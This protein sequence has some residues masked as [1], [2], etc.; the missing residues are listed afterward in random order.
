MYVRLKR[1]DPL[2][3]VTDWLEASRFVRTYIMVHGIGSSEFTGG[4]VYN[5]GQR[6]IGHISYNGRTWNK[7]GQEV[8]L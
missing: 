2:V 6:K 3:R 1:G 5:E 4:Q 8:L 7:D